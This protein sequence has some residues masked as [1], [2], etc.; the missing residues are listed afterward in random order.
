MSNGVD[1]SYASQMHAAE[2]APVDAPA[3]RVAYALW[4]LPCRAFASKFKI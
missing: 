1:E 2:Q 4:Q 3:H